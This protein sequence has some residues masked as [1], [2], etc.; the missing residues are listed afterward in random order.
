MIVLGIDPGTKRIGY[1]LVQKR[2]LHLTCLEAG[3]LEVH[4][5][6]PELVLQEAQ[7]GL[8]KVIKKFKPDLLAIERL[9][10]AKNKKTA[11]AV[12]EARGVV[13]LSAAEFGLKIVE[14]APNAVKLGVAG[15]G[16][17]DKKA[18]WKMVSLT[19]GL[20]G[21]ILDDASD[22]LALAI[23]GCGEKPV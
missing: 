7:R 18:V 6:K 4:A 21:K 22:A 13:L 3:I 20:T 10:F 2:G 9:Y 19:L 14:Y 12:A 5:L 15:Y 16:K 1:G 8:E 17:A 23:L 11:L